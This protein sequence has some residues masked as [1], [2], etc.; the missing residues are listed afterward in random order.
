MIKKEILRVELKTEQGEV[1]HVLGIPCPR[2]TVP[3]TASLV[4]E[5]L[6]ETFTDAMK[7]FEAKFG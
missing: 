4:G 7:E 2:G 1:L 6:T 5:L 3:K